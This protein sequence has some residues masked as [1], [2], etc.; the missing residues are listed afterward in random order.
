MLL[1]VG[2]IIQKDLISLDV[3]KINFD[4]KESVKSLIITL[5]NVV[6]Q[7]LQENQQLRVE[8]QQLK[9]E[10][11]RLKGEKGKPKIAPNVP[12]REPKLLPAE[13][14]KKWSK[15]SKMPKI[16]IDRVVL[17][18]INPDTLPPDA[19]CKGHSSIIIQNIR[20]QTDNVEYQ[21]EHYYSPSLNRNYYAELPK[22]VQNT[23]FGSDLKAFATELYYVG[24]VT[25][26]KIHRILTD[27]G[28][29]ISEGEISNILSKEKSEAFAAEKADIF[30]MGMM[31][32][33]YF[34]TD[35]TGARHQGKNYYM[36]YFGNET[37]S[38]Y[39]IEK[40]KSRGTIRKI[41]GLLEGVLAPTPMTTDGA[42]Q[43]KGIAIWHALCWIHE[44]R[45]YKKLRPFLDFHRSILEKFMINLWDF[46]DLLRI[47]KSDPNINLKGEIEQEFDSLFTRTTGYIELDRRIALTFKNRKELLAVLESPE[48]PLHNN[49]SEIAVREGVLKRKISYGTRSDL[50][51]AAWENMFS[52]LDTCRK[53]KVNFF[54]YVRDIYSNDFCMPRLADLLAKAE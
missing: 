39:F 7:L 47:Y 45:F 21:R 24:R 33:N 52:I 29:I 18:K 15:D 19:V 13:K 3:D 26:N 35:E 12:A 1:I 30:Q 14:S 2:E 5:L 42:R 44:I 34:Q 51:K 54:K 37:F 22:D 27:F 4:D 23:Q 16:K 41:L 8:V 49:G 32:A 20:L 40:S 38:T 46:Y 31:H 9:D 6:E 48:V 36:H 53:Q 43:Y 10:N 50:G 17:L 11:A 28:T 25:E